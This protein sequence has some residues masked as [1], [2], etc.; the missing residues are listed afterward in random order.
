MTFNRP[1]GPCKP[2][3][4]PESISIF[5]YCSPQTQLIVYPVIVNF[6]TLNAMIKLAIA[7]EAII[8]F[9]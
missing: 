5:E 6:E 9:D 3:N 1:N 8:E 2:A 7:D 4:S